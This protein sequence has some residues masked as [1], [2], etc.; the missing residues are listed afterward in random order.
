MRPPDTEISASNI[1][2]A[3]ETFPLETPSSPSTE[4]F[5][6]TDEYNN[7]FLNPS[8]SQECTSS[9]N[10]LSPH[11]GLQEAHSLH[12]CAR[13]IKS[14]NNN[15]QHQ[16]PACKK[17][18]TMN[19]IKK[20]LADDQHCRVISAT[21]VNSYMAK[22]DMWR[23]L[24]CKQINDNKSNS[25]AKRKCKTMRTINH[26]MGLDIQLDPALFENNKS[27]INPQYESEALIKIIKLMLLD[28]HKTYTYLPK[29]SRKLFGKLLIKHLIELNK[30]I[31]NLKSWMKFIALPKLANRVKPLEM[32]VSH[33]CYASQNMKM[34][35]DINDED[36][37]N[38]IMKLANEIIP[39]NNSAMNENVIL[40]RKGK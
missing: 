1:Q 31:N 35:N 20:H 29:T 3:T 21:I 16:C 13:N 26:G 32:D 17:F 24:K 30:D 5:S 18:L 11:L 27:E 34:L 25:C 39:K 12:C 7:N 33:R 15:N 22:H 4:Y 9:P 19:T 38:L 23:C 6:D 37:F 10:V 2:Y 8:T 14:N 28:E 36:H 40:N